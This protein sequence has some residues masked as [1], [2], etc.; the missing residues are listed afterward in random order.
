[1]LHRRLGGQTKR[2]GSSGAAADQHLGALLVELGDDRLRRRRPGAKTTAHGQGITAAG[3]L[4][5]LAAGRQAPQGLMLRIAI[6]QR[7][8]RLGR[9]QRSLRTPARSFEDLLAQRGHGN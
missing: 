6:A 3:D 4:E 5:E 2:I 1:M 9:Q 8:E 7:Q